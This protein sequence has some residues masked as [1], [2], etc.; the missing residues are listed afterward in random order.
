MVWTARI[1]RRNGILAVVKDLAKQSHNRIGRRRTEGLVVTPCRPLVPSRAVQP[2]QDGDD[3]FGGG[4]K[5][6]A[7]RRSKDN[8]A[9][10]NS[11]ETKRFA[12]EGE[13]K[14]TIGIPRTELESGYDGVLRGGIS[15]DGS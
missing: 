12:L 1:G 10:V 11:V 4:G 13:L 15:Y 7:A 6:R 3:S 9:A 2:R 5:N 8:S 14:F